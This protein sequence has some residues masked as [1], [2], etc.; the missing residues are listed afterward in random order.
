MKEHLLLCRLLCSILLL[1]ALTCK[2]IVDSTSNGTL[3]P[4]E[5]KAIN[6]LFKR[7]PR[8]SKLDDDRNFSASDCNKKFT[9]LVICDCNAACTVTGLYLSSAGLKGEIPKEIGKLTSLATLYLANNKFSKI[10]SSLQN[11]SKLSSILLD[12]NFLGGHIP[13]FFSQMKSLTMLSL[14]DNNFDGPIPPELGALP[15]LLELYLDG[16]LLSGQIPSQLGNLSNLMALDLSDNGLS[17]E[18]PDELGHLTNLRHL[19]LPNNNFN[20]N[21]LQSF[22]QLKN[23]AYFDIRGNNFNG[24]IPAFIAQWKHASKLYLMGNNFEW[25]D[26]HGVFQSL[27]NLEILQLA[28]ITGSPGQDTDF[29][30]VNTQSLKHLTLRNCSLGGQ[31]PEFIWRSRSLEY[32]DLSFNNLVGELPTFASDNL[33]YI[34]LKGNML[35]NSSL[36]WF[37]NI[38]NSSVDIS[39]NKFPSLPLPDKSITKNWNLFSCCSN[40]T[41]MPI[42]AWG[43]QDYHCDN[44]KLK[45]DHLYINCGGGVASINGTEYEADN[46][47]L[48]GS[49]HFFLSP[50]KKWGYSSMGS[51]SESYPGWWS[52]SPFRSP[53]PSQSKYL[54]YKTC[55]LNMSDAILYST[56]RIAPIS[57]KYYGFCL[58]NGHYIVKLH[59]AE[60]AWNQ[61]RGLNQTKLSSTLKRIFNVKIQDKQVMTNFNIVEQAKGVDQSI[62]QEFEVHVNNSQLEIHL[63][64]AGKGSTGYRFSQYGPLISGISVHRVKD[65]LSPLVI[66][67]IVASALLIVALALLLLWEL[68][69]FRK[70][71]LHDEELKGMELLS[72]SFFNARQIKA[73]TQ[74]FSPAMKLGE[75]GFGSVYKGVLLNGTAIAVKQ[76]SSKS[77]QGIHEFVN[78]VGTISALQHPNLVKLLGCCAEDNQLLL[79]YEF[80]ENNSLAHALFGPNEVRSRLNWPTRVQICLG[81]AKGLTF[82]H[83]ESK[84]KIVHRDI[85]PT[86]ILLDKD[87][88]AKISDFGFAKLYEEEVTH[89]VT[90][91]AGTTGYMAPEYA[92]R[93]HLTNK[94][95]VYSFGVVTLEIVSGKNSTSYRP[96]DENV[97]LLDLAY[98]LQ[99]KGNLVEL[100]DPSL[101]SDYSSEQANTILEL[102]MSC[103]NPSPSL[104]RPMSEV[105]KILEERV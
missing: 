7:F 16:N 22:D 83:E 94:A 100:V 30:I 63:Y 37:T 25:P 80:M 90:K 21:L 47:T 78:E 35:N 49:S 93:G 2:T 53:S 15:Y 36:G 31:I 62:T 8:T 89:V 99:Q 102:A 33:K 51:F 9:N 26:S 85:K 66:A 82:L 92:M 18:L 27:K 101:G 11:L 69:C 32:L 65:K 12:D 24:Q 42:E 43:Q 103:T 52:P 1:S 17:G 105:V 3:P 86:N 45:Y 54:S 23:M 104:R 6:S 91:I 87:F 4:E 81:I 38:S 44:K 72:G 56:A 48:G 77:G 34:Y 95:D 79:V 58:K 50:N 96:N 13:T 46:E 60:I 39:E 76:L 5:V 28:D 61:Q 88:N 97:Y 98:V 73:A 40:I 74:N 10:P 55:D 29:P 84:L 68:G 71:G 70:K 14:T 57:L 67:G 20:G 41:D 75:G 64:W 59:F 19:Y